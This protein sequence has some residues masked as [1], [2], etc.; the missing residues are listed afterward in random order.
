MALGFYNTIPVRASP[1]FARISSPPWNCKHCV[2]CGNKTSDPPLSPPSPPPDNFSEGTPQPVVN[3]TIVLDLTSLHTRGLLNFLLASNV[4]MHGQHCDSA[5][6]W[7]VCE[8][9]CDTVR[10]V[11]SEGLRFDSQPDPYGG[12]LFLSLNLT[13]SSFLYIQN[14]MTTSVISVF[15]VAMFSQ[16]RLIRVLLLKCCHLVP[17]YMDKASLLM[18]YFLHEIVVFISRSPQSS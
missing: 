3:W 9:Y 2:R 5:R 15:L 4:S 17:H 16:G 6:H 12:L 18:P 14:F 8:Q 1:P 10:L 11:K 13:P 7:S